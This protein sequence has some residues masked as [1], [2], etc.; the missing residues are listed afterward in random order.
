[1][2]LYPRIKIH[3]KTWGLIF[4]G[5]SLLANFWGCLGIKE[6][7]S[8]GFRHKWELWVFEV[9]YASTASGMRTLVR[10]V[11]S[12]LIPRGDEARYFGLITLSIT[13]TWAGLL[14]T[15]VIQDRTGNLWFPFL[16]N[17]FVVI[18]AMVVFNFVDCEQGMRDADKQTEANPSTVDL[19]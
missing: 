18:A 17:V 15:A 16:P 4:L 11:F 13:I 8:I 2:W 5:V 7:L 3:I 14:V 10:T 19:Q 6:S 9:I 12:G 1:M